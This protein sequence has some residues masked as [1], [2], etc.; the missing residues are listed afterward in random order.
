MKDKHYLAGPLRGDEEAN[1]EAAR[2]WARECAR[3]GLYF[4]CP[5]LN[6]QGLNDAAPDDWWLAMDIAI[7]A[8]CDVLLLLPG[9]ETSEGAHGE[10]AFAEDMDIDVYEIAEYFKLI[11]GDGGANH[12]GAEAQRGDDK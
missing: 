12:R 11:D 4:F 8:D 2:H 9:W 10:K 1:L 5:H 7:L 3:R 6:S